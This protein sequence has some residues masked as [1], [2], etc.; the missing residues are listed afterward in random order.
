MPSDTLALLL[1]ALVNDDFP[2]LSLTERNSSSEEQQEGRGAQG[3]SGDCRRVNW[4]GRMSCMVRNPSDI[5]LSIPNIVETDGVTQYEIEVKIGEVSWR[6]FHRYRDFQELHEKL[7]SER[8]VSKDLLPPKKVIGNRNPAFV[9]KR[10]AGLEKY[11]REVLIYLQLTMPRE[12]VEFLHLHEYDI[13]HLLHTMAER[14]YL[15]GD[16]VLSG[17]RSQTFSVLELHAISERLKLPSEVSE[18]KYDFSHVLDFCS[19]LERVIVMPRRGENALEGRSRADLPLGSSN[20]I[21]QSLKFDMVAF[22]TLQEIQLIGVSPAS[23]V[24]AA[25]IRDSLKTLHVH[26]TDTQRLSD[27]LLCDDIH[28]TAVSDPEKVWRSVEVA[29]FSDNK[30][31]AIDESIKLLPKIATLTLDRNELT[32][33]QNLNAMPCLSA[34]SLTE[35]KIAQCLDWHLELGNLVTL[36]L[37]QNFIQ[38]LAGFRKMYSLVNLDV[39]CNQIG[40]IDEVDHLANLPCI[41]NIKLTGNP[42]AGSVDYRSKVLS[43]FVERIGEMC[44]DNEKA[45]QKEVDT[46]LVL[47]ALKISQDKMDSPRKVSSSLGLLR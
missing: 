3:I 18:K 37:S 19:Q 33:V 34:L 25:A 24:N 29:N 21:P 45:S 9:E 27:V 11:L 47:A 20:I 39:S 41:E 43:R 38:S 31:I 42:V 22:K 44:L 36:I 23:I 26:L 13:I 1:A 17:S 7:V 35:N 10:K 30:L 8:S 6:V 32:T 12:F 40:D 46:A 14:F 2:E 16:S 4:P 15:D 5:T 28:K